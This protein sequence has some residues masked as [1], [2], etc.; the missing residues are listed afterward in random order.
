[1]S[2]SGNTVRSG[3]SPALQ[4][5][6]GS[7]SGVRRL[8]LGNADVSED[9][10]TLQGQLFAL[11]ANLESERQAL[12]A[13]R[14]ELEASRTAL[15]LARSELAD[16]RAELAAARA[17]SLPAAVA[18]PEAPAVEGSADAGDVTEVGAEDLEGDTPLAEVIVLNVARAEPP[19]IVR[20]PELPKPL[21]A[22]APVDATLRRL[23]V[24]SAPPALVEEDAAV[25]EGR[26]HS[27]R[28][29]CE[30]E[31][32]FTHDTHFTAGLTRDLSTGGVFVATY[33]KIPIGDSVHL[34]FDLP[35]DV[36]VEVR[37]E[38]RWIRDG[39]DESAR[40]GLGIAFTEVSPEALAAIT[41]FCRGRPPLYFEL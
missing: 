20:P 23:V 16:V 26:R 40:P 19:R 3:I 29:A 32:E 36:H 12:R 38:V 7:V 39:E 35:G 37:G 1:M 5:V 4:G 31:V 28:T 30:F 6:A 10:S 2:K 18:A 11:E 22:E 34:A 21:E 41:R 25:S 15:A 9:V 27:I 17:V 8:D 13:A 14:E 33:Q 24:S